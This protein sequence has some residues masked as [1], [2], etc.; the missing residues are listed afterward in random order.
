MERTL[1]T[2]TCY[3]DKCPYGFRMVVEG[4]S[5]ADPPR[6]ICRPSSVE[7]A[8]SG[9]RKAVTQA[10]REALRAVDEKLAR[11]REAQRKAEQQREAKVVLDGALSVCAFLPYVPLCESSLILPA[12]GLQFT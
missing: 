5:A 4:A 2:A 6:V 10:N 3:A 11:V 8:T 9:V 7:A 12:C 1:I